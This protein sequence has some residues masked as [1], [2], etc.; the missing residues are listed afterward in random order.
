MEDVKGEKSDSRRRGQL[1]VGS[2]LQVIEVG[3]RQCGGG[4]D[5]CREAPLVTRHV[6]TSLLS[7]DWTLEKR[8]QID[9]CSSFFLLD[10]QKNIFANLHV[11]G[12]S[13]TFLTLSFF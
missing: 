2:L 6:P 11:S 9:F 3:V 5:S 8:G 13:K 12:N 7:L 1:R 4:G 10:R